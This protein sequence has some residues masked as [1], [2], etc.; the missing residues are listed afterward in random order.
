MKNKTPAETLGAELLQTVL[1]YIETRPTNHELAVLLQFVEYIKSNLKTS[2][3]CNEPTPDMDEELEPDETLSDSTGLERGEL[4]E[5]IQ[6][7]LLRYAK[8]HPTGEYTSIGDFL[9]SDYFGEIT[10]IE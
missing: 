2:L 5:L 1:E 9:D 8:Q 4:K 3:E 6:T 7:E 10:D